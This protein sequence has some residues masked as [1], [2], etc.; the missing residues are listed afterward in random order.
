MIMIIIII[1]MGLCA[2]IPAHHRITNLAFFKVAHFRGGVNL[3][4]SSRKVALVLIYCFFRGW[5]SR[6]F[7]LVFPV[8]T[9]LNP[10]VTQEILPIAEYICV[11][12][13]YT[14][15]AWSNNHRVDVNLLGHL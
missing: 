11:Y 8:M 9:V 1:P 3:C 2:V 12:F 6:S 4:G 14:F 10:Q 5:L 7:H 15:S 13:N